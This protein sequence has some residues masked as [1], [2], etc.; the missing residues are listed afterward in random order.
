MSDMAPPG[1]HFQPEWALDQLPGDQGEAW[2]VLF[3]HGSLEL[4]IYAPRGHD[5]Q[6][7]HD[8]DEIYIVISGTGTFLN[9]RRRH[10]F[11]PGDLLFVPAGTVHRFEDFSDDFATW[12]IFYGPE[13]GE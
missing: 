1:H 8:R 6:Q 10:G 3:E 4:E 11:K 12:V 5:P 9:G 2:R 13:G 7:P